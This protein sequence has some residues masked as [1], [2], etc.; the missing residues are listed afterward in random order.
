MPMGK[1]ARTL[2]IKEDIRGNTQKAYVGP[3]SYPPSLGIFWE[4]LSV[5]ARIRGG[6]NEERYL[7]YSDVNDIDVLQLGICRG[8]GHRTR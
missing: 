6:D 8:T 5:I 1:R 4:S 2:T 3:I 7:N